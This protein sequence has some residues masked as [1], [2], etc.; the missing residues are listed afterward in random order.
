MTTP[1][2]VAALVNQLAIEAVCPINHQPTT[3]TEKNM[4]RVFTEFGL[5]VANSLQSLSPPAGMV[6]PE[7]LNPATKLLVLRFAEALAEKL[8]VAEQK[9][10]YSDGWLDDSW[11]DEC[12][13]KL[14]EH[15]DKGDPRDVAAYCAFLWYHKQS[16][17][18]PAP[19]AGM[20]DL[21]KAAHM[22]QKN[23]NYTAG[24]A[25]GDPRKGAGNYLADALIRLS[26]AQKEQEEKTD[27]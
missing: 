20:D 14:R 15:T 4:V 6:M 22:I 27:D 24:L 16:T 17:K 9:Y 8:F 25:D 5:Q 11:M 3:P 26:D 7:K 1:D 12:R 10:G 18:S 21:I 2:E 23:S 13:R 19:P